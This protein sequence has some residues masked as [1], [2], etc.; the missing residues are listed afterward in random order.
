MNS[1]SNNKFPLVSIIA[2]NF[3]NSQY[4]VETLDSIA[5]QTYSN[6]ELIIVDDCSTDDS[7]EKIESWLSD[8]KKSFQFIASIKNEG[9]CATG[10]KGL[11]VANGKYISFIATDDVMLPAKI[12]KQV[13]L[14]ESLLKEV[15]MIYSDAYLIDDNSN[16]LFGTFIQK[17]RN[18]D[19]VP[20]GYIFEDLIEGNYIP[21]M[22]TLI[23][24]SVFDVV[25][26]FDEDLI[27]EDYDMWLRIAKKYK[28]FFQDDIT[29]KYRK[30]KGSL[31]QVLNFY[32]WHKNNIKIFTKHAD[33]EAVRRKLENLIVQ[34]YFQNYPYKE[35]TR[36]CDVQG[37]GFTYW[38]MKF[39]VP[40]NITKAI[41]AF[42]GY[43]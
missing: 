2:V 3:N 15:G 29:V 36:I 25:G 39:G 8:Y 31:T 7:V 37:S 14:F 18:F 16:Q 20:S 10:N 27:Y 34:S 35:L 28:I 19:K 30:R 33:N 12:S 11:K 43:I 22:A 9:V 32:D 17:H 6:T 21:G 5:A 1:S 38:C 13:S 24:S 40:S 41:L 42:G 4:V 23:K 26:L